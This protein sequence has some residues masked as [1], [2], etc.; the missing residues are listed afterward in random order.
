[1][2]TATFNHQYNADPHSLPTNQLVEQ[3]LRA[4]IRAFDTSPYY[5]PAE[6]LLGKAFHTDYVKKNFKRE[7]IIVCTKVGRI[8]GDCFDYSRE[9][10]RKS[11]KQSCERLKTNYLDVV[12][13]HDVEFVSE[14]EVLEAVTELRRLRDEEGVLT[15]IGISGYPVEVLCRLAER[16]YEVTGEPLDLVMSYANYTVQNTRLLSKGVKRLKNAGVNCVLNGSPLG[17]G[18]MRKQGVPVGSMGDFHPASDG[19]RHA[20]HA[21]S[22]FTDNEGEDLA[23]LSVR[24]A[25]ESWAREAASVGSDLQQ[26]IDRNGQRLRTNTTKIGVTVFGVSNLAELEQTLKLYQDI[27]LSING[28]ETQGRR[29]KTVNLLVDGARKVIGDY[30]DTTW[31]SPGKDYVRKPRTF[32][33]SPSLNPRR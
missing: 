12:Y 29:W 20:C 30:V 6:Q 26:E 10:V 24:Y 23:A 25:Y 13:C 2:G 5:G 11:I 4:G 15:Y 31:D 28:D 9:W 1:M 27:I 3:A 16:I 7:D 14:E 8:S 17:M 22:E 21:A 33:D 18:L 19:L 32:R